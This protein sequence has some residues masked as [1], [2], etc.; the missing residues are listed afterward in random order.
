M[1]GPLEDIISIILDEIALKTTVVRLH[2]CCHYI[3]QEDRRLVQFKNKGFLLVYKDVH[4][5][6][7]HNTASLLF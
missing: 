1:N 2:N 6:N 7:V 3:R 4:Y 5:N